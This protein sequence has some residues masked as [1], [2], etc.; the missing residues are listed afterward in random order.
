MLTAA[1]YEARKFGIHSG[2]PSR[3]A[4]AKCPWL[5]FIRLRFDVYREIS[6]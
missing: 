4:I 2:M 1:S 6:T 5:I 3:T